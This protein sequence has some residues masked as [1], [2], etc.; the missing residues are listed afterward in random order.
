M[1]LGNGI[2]VPFS[3]GGGG[4]GGSPKVYI[5]D[6]FPAHRARGLI[7]MKS[8]YTGALLKIRRPSDNAVK[9]FYPDTDGKLSLSSTDGSGTTL[10]SWITTED[11]FVHTYYDQM[12]S[13][14][15]W[16]Q[17][18]MASQP[19]IITSGAVELG[20]NSVLAA[21][22]NVSRMRKNSLANLGLLNRSLNISTRTR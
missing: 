1:V 4:G 15:N 12:G 8:D 10:S 7:L 5:L 18:V 22:S 14:D 19:Q 16:V 6:D 21:D 9:D 13:G 20:S 11:G 17:T 3:K 2:G